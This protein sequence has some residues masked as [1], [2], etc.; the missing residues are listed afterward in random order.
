MRR[1]LSWKATVACSLSFVMFAQ[2]ASAQITLV[3]GAGEMQTVSPKSDAKKCCQT[4]PWSRFESVYRQV[5]AAQAIA[6]ALRRAHL[7]RLQCLHVHQGAIRC[8]S[9]NASSRGKT[10]RPFGGHSLSHEL[11]WD[12]SSPLD[13]AKLRLTCIANTS[14][15]LGSLADC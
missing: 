2:I 13:D 6:P 9:V 14:E 5:S 11:A 1:S 8:C 7:S 10:E 3:C 4:R 12:E 15:D